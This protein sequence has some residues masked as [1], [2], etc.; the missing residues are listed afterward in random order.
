MR[1]NHKSNSVRR[2]WQQGVCAAACTLAL[3][4]PASAAS[5]S[6][7][8]GNA[9]YAAAVSETVDAGL[10]SGVGGGAFDPDGTVT[11]AMTV[12]ALW[13]LAGQPAAAAGNHFSDVA[14]GTW[15]TAAVDWAAEC[16]VASGDG[17][18]NFSPEMPVT[19][20]QLAVL[21]YQYARHQGLDTA[22]GKLDAY[23]D[24]KTVSKWAV[25][26]MEHAVGAGIISGSGGKLR[27]GD[28]ADRA[29]LAVMLE[30]LMTPA[31]G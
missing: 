25:D 13:R 8:P 15:Y 1:R 24:G 6:D 2:R 23:T 9:W 27:P 21:L 14:E 22:Q 18:G 30:R 3:L 11:R 17:K 12:T 28:R 10:L 20:E 5:F 7:V 29:E 31:V 4:L 16:G 26:G 19:R